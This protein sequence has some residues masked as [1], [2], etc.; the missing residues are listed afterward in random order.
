M[1]ILLGLQVFNICRVHSPEINTQ[2]KLRKVFVRLLNADDATEI[3]MSDS[4]LQIIINNY[5]KSRNVRLDF[6]QTD[7]SAC[8]NCKSLQYAALQYNQKVKEL[9]CKL[10]DRQPDSGSRPLSESHRE[11]TRSFPA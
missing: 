8:P 1:G 6:K 2:E 7:H 10:D 5:M 9:I 11:E 4:A 3:L